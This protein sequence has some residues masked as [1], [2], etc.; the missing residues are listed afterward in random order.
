MPISPKAPIFGAGA[1]IGYVH[2]CT[3]C[4]FRLKRLLLVQEHKSVINPWSFAEHIFQ[5]K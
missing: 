4:R 1:K 5:L 3:V 2:G